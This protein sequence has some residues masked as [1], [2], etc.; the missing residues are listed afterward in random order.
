MSCAII[1]ATWCW[2]TKTSNWVEVLHHLRANSSAWL[3]A[4]LGWL[5][6]KEIYVVL[7]Q[8]PRIGGLNFRETYITSPRERTFIAF[9]RPEVVMKSQS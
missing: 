2:S 6:G 4:W 9:R 8:A 3:Q 7:R 5:W 1:L